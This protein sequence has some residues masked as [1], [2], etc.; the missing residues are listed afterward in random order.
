R[1]G[2]TVRRDGDDGLYR[3]EVD[4]VG[5]VGRRGERRDPEMVG[6]ASDPGGDLAAV[7]DEQRLDGRWPGRFSS[8]RPVDRAN[9]VIRD[10]PSSSNTPR[11]QTTGRD[12]ALD[13]P[14]ARPDPAGRL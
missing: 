10:T 7:R 13:R 6:G 1:S 5:P 4:G 9:R 14:R 3:E 12:P 2:A 11:G 8:V